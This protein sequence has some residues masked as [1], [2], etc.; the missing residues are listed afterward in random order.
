M[1]GIE[2]SVQHLKFP[3]IA[4]ITY[5]N[6]LTNKLTHLYN[7]V[8]VFPTALI[9]CLIRPLGPRLVKVGSARPVPRDLTLP[10]LLTPFKDFLLSF[11][12]PVFPP[13]PPLAAPLP[14]PPS[15]PPFVFFC[16]DLPEADLFRLKFLSLGF[17]VRF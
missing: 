8:L 7:P 3:T 4:Q 13:P 2:T 17:S 10:L 15:P 5:A 12:L 14:P 16:P 11:L 1:V 9:C 6:T